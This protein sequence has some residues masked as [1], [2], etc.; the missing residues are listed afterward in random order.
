MEHFALS[1]LKR[2]PYEIEYLFHITHVNNLQSIHRHGLL[3]H[4]RSH[5]GGY[6]KVDIANPEVI[7]IRA[8]KTVQI[9]DRAL[10]HYS[11]GRLL[12]DYVPLFFTPKTPMLHNRK[13]MQDDIAILC[14]SAALLLGG[15]VVFTD[16]NAANSSTAFF[17]DLRS[18]DKLD[19]KCIRSKSSTPWIEAQDFEEWKRKRS[20]EVLVPHHI[21]FSEVQRI[22][23]RTKDVKQRLLENLLFKAEVRPRWF[24]DN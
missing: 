19:W 10:H 21:S 24:F 9:S 13:E 4:N 22:I 8:R 2:K 11:S 7:G 17:N 3:S 12:H 14:L 6:T 1:S 23:V 15:I 5:S 18:I 20:A 16:G